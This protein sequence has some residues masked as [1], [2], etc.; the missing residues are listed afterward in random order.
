M[1]VLLQHPAGTLA[2]WRAAR[3][4][5]RRLR[6]PCRNRCPDRWLPSTIHERRRLLRQQRRISLSFSSSR[7]ASRR[8][9]LGPSLHVSHKCNVSLEQRQSLGW[10]AVERR[11]NQAEVDAVALRRP[12]GR[13]P[14]RLLMRDV[15]GPESF[16]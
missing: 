8:S 4:E 6:Y 9:S 5:P 14:D 13:Q 16:V 3:R 1:E 11:P 12:R 2:T 10:G 7:Q 15:T